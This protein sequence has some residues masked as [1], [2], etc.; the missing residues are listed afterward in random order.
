MFQYATGWLGWAPDVALDTPLP[1]IELALDG[2]I[3]FLK[4]T[5]PW[6]SDGK[7]KGRKDRNEPAMALEKPAETR[8]EKAA[9]AQKLGAAFRGLKARAG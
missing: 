8:A 6:G 7:T 5:N 3:D 9:L 1:Q 2:K 4:K